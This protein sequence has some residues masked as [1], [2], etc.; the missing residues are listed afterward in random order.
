MSASGY[1]AVWATDNTREALF[2]KTRDRYDQACDKGHQE[3]CRVHAQLDA[4]LRE[5]LPELLTYGDFDL[6]TRT[7]PAIWL[8]AATVGAIEGVE[9]ASI[10]AQSLERGLAAGPDLSGAGGSRLGGAVEP[11]V[12]LGTGQLPGSHRRRPPE[13][14]RSYRQHCDHC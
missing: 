7:G 12:E 2:D 3:A 4:A 14:S 8:R 1:A 10:D 9:A 6:T 5:R 13:N 11:G